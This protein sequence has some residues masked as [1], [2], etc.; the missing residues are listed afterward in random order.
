MLPDSA[1]ISSTE[2]KRKQEILSGYMLEASTFAISCMVMSPNGSDPS[3]S[4]CRV[5]ILDISVFRA[6]LGEP[7][8]VVCGPS[9]WRL[10]SCNSVV[11]WAIPFAFALLVL[12]G[13]PWNWIWRPWKFMERGFILKGLLG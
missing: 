2:K 9:C 13:W 11:S 3:F 6:T 12:L 4:V 10:M 5:F 7:S 1:I 8:T